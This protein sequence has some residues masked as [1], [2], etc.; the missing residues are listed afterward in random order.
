MQDLTQGPTAQR[1]T[2]HFGVDDEAGVEKKE[3]YKF[4]SGDVAKVH[5]WASWPRSRAQGITTTITSV[6]LPAWEFIGVETC[7]GVLLLPAHSA[8]SGD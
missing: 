4:P 6:S 3:R 8:R 2:R 7:L 1:R 5:R